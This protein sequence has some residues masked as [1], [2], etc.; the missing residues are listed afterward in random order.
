MIKQLNYYTKEIMELSP[1]AMAY[2]IN[3]K[4]HTETLK[5]IWND[6]KAKRH[7][8]VHSVVVQDV[9]ADSSWLS[10]LDLDMPDSTTALESFKLLEDALHE[11]TFLPQEEEDYKRF[12]IAQTMIATPKQ[13]ADIDRCFT[14]VM[15]HVRKA[16]EKQPGLAY[17]VLYF[18]ECF[19]EQYKNKQYLDAAG[20]AITVGLTY[21]YILCKEVKAIQDYYHQAREFIR[22]AFI[23]PCEWGVQILPER[24]VDLY[25]L[26]CSNNNMSNFYRN[27]NARYIDFPSLR[28]KETPTWEVFL[29]E[30]AYREKSVRG[31]YYIG[32][33]PQFIHIGIDRLIDSQSVLRKC[34]LCGGYFK[35]K[36]NST[37][38]CC[39]R[40]Y[41]DTA[42]TC[43]EYV[44][45]KTYKTKLSEHPIHS[46]YQTAYNRLYG[47][48]RRKAV[49]ADTPL[50]ESL[51]KLRDKYYKKYEEATDKTRPAILEEY[52][53]KSKDLLG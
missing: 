12:S 47:R 22:E 8:E 51:K 44:S 27:T 28:S 41:K 14:N 20:Q 16:V 38:T 40:I 6:F 19:K 4:K 17:I 25:N 42:T 10:L 11:Y 21:Y 48:I 5:T 29:Q 50:L 26:Y 49:P 34:A 35:T 32:S 3:Q 15:K 37:Q 9:P 53:K 13:Y 33:F 36:F 30:N 39:S 18:V 45:R 1:A 43:Y 7:G 24:A 46:A 2:E 23:K 31:T 52:V